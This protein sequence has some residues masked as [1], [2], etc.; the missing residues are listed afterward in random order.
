M[1]APY[2]QRSLEPPPQVS[3]G[4]PTVYAIQSRLDPLHDHAALELCAHPRAFERV[5]L[6]KAKPD[7]PWGK[8]WRLCQ[9]SVRPSESGVDGPSL[10][11]A[12]AGFPTKWLGFLPV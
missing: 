2:I 12:S 4:R 1:G 9:S 3:R 8:A 10:R 7:Q 5:T 6:R 11:V